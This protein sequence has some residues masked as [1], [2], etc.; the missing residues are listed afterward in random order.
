MISQTPITVMFYNVENLFDTVDDPKTQDEEFLPTSELKW[1]DAKYLSKIKR[2]AQ[3]VDSSVLGIDLPDVVGFCEI[4]NKKVL[5]DLI[6]LTQLKA[7]KYNVLTSSGIDDRGINVGFIYNT[8]VFELIQST[9]LNVTSADIANYKTRNVLVVTLKCISTK[10]IIYFFVNHWPSRRDGEKETEP[11]R[12]YAAKTVKQKVDELLKQ[13]GNAKI[14]VMGDFNDYP[15]NS[16]VLNVLQANANPKKGSNELLNPYFNIE[17]NK[18][19]THFDR[20]EWHVLDQI[21]LS[22]GFLQKTGLKFKTNNA[23]ILKKDF[24]LFKNTKTGE[25]KPNRTYGGGNKYYN[26]Y[27]DHLAVYVQLNF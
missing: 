15:T 4:E 3:V 26:G 7:K 11:K 16:S 20:G 9:E 23:F 18:E 2:I 27:S 17:K 25:I 12:I 14:I 10:E 5:S 6:A 19:G 13:N 8:S 22:Q 1:D 21:V 24:L